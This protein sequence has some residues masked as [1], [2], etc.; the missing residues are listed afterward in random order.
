MTDEQFLQA[1]RIKPETFDVP[2]LS[3]TAIRYVT[4]WR[5]AQTYIA[6]MTSPQFLLLE[7][8]I[9]EMMI[10]S[11]VNMQRQLK[12]WRNLGLYCFGVIM[13]AVAC[14]LAGVGYDWMSQHGS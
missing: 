7:P 3:Q 13:L 2:V 6:T 8:S 5:D 10:A 9:V 11:E 14:V 12:K 4:F 1:L